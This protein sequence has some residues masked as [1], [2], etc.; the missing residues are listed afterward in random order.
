MATTKDVT[1]LYA[2]RWSAS[3]TWGGEVPPKEGETVQIPA[4]LTLL[5]DVPTPK[6]ML[7]LIEGALIVE[8]VPGITLDANYIFINRGSFQVG[9]PALPYQ[10]QFTLTLHGRRESPM[11]PIYGNKVLAVYRGVLDMHGIPRTV[12]WTSLEYTINPYASSFTVQVATDW[13]VGESVVVASTSYDHTDAE[14]RVITAVSGGGKEFTVSKPFLKKHYAATETYGSQTIEM[15]AEVGLLTRNVRVRGSEEGLDQEHGAHIMAYSKGDDSVIARITYI[16]IFNAGQA[17]SIGAYPIHFHMIGAVRNS[18]IIGNGIHH[19]FNRAITIHAIQYL[20]VI[21]NVSY[22]TKGHTIFVEDGAEMKNRIVHNLVVSVRRSWSR[23]NT[24]TTPAGIWVTNPDNYVTDNHVAGSDAYGIWFDFKANP[25][26]PSATTL[27]CPVGTPLAEFNNNVAHSNGKYGFRLFH[28]HIP[29]TYPC[30]PAT[31][32]TALDPWADNPPVTA[33]YRNFVGYKN[34]R[35]GAIAD[36]VGDVRWQNFKVADNLLA[37]IEITY[38]LDT[39]PFTIPFLSNAL[40]IGKSLNTEADVSM[41]GSIG[42]IGPQSDGLI[43]ENLAFYN[44]DNSMYALGDESHSSACTTR[45]HGGRHNKLRGLTFGNANKRVHWEFPRRSFYEIEDAS[46][47]GRAGAFVA[48]FWPHLLWEPYCTYDEATYNGIICDGT[49]VIRRVHMLDLQPS[50]TFGLMQIT[51]RRAAGSNLPMGTG[52]FLPSEPNYWWTS[53]GPVGG[54]QYHN[55]PKAWAVPMIMGTEYLVH[56]GTTPM[57][58]TSMTIRIE[59][60]DDPSLWVHVRF[61]FTD[62]REMFEVRRGTLPAGTKS[63][64]VG[65]VD[66]TLLPSQAALTPTSPA[67]ASSFDNTTAMEFRTVLTGQPVIKANSGDLQVKAYRCYGGHCTLKLVDDNVTM[68]TFKR[69]WSNPNSWPSGAIPVEGESVTIE[70]GWSM[71]LD[72]NTAIMSF[73]EVNGDLVFDNTTS[74]TLN[75][76]MIHVRKGRILS[77]SQQYPLLPNITHQIVINGTFNSL[78]YAFDPNIEVVNKAL[79]ITGNM[80]LYGA[81]RRAWV[82]LVQN[83]KPGDTA[84]FVERTNWQAGDQ[85]VLTSSSF[86]QNETETNTVAS[87]QGGI[88][89]VTGVNSGVDL[90]SDALWTS[91]ESTKSFGRYSKEMYKEQYD[92]VDSKTVTKLTLSQPLQYYHAGTTLLV[93]GSPMDMRGEVGVLTSNIIIRGTENG[94]T[95]NFVVADFVDY[96]VVGSNPILR[97]GSVTLDSI[98]IDYCGQNSTLRTGLR[99][100]STTLPSVVSN[101]IV[102]RSQTYSVNIQNSKNVRLLGNTFFYAVRFGVFVQ[103]SSDLLIDGNLMINVTQRPTISLPFDKPTGYVICPEER[104]NC[105]NV[106]VSNNVAAGYALLGFADGGYQCGK[107]ATFYN[108]VAHSGVNGWITSNTGAACVEMSGFRSYFNSETAVVGSMDG[109]EIIFS[110]LQIADS[111]NG[112]GGNMGGERDSGNL[113][114]IKDSLIVGKTGHSF[115]D[116]NECWTPQCGNRRGIIFSTYLVEAKQWTI[117]GKLKLPIYNVSK[118]AVFNAE[119]HY[120]N[121]VFANFNS[122]D[123]CKA[124]ITALA[125]NELSSDYTPVQIFS[126]VKLINVANDSIFYMADPDPQWAS[127]LFCGEFPCTGL[128]NA[129]VRDMDGGLVGSSNGGYLLPNNPGIIHREGCTFVGRSNGYMCQ[130]SQLYNYDY[131]LL[132]FE[133]LDIDTREVTISPIYIT[134]EDPILNVNSTHYYNK[135]NSFMSHIWDGFYVGTNRLGR[136]PTAIGLNRKFNVTFTATAPERMR[137]QLQGALKWT[138]SVVLTVNYKEPY[139]VKVKLNGTEQWY[140]PYGQQVN[141]TAPSGT[142]RWLHEDRMMQFIIRPGDIVEL[143]K[144]DCIQ[145]SIR[146]NM[147]T[148]EFFATN[149]QTE[150]VDRLASVLGIPPYRIRVASIRSGSTICDTFINADE[151]LTSKRASSTSYSNAGLEDLTRLNALLLAKASNGTL[152]LNAP[153]LSVNSSI[154][155]VSPGLSPGMNSNSS[156]PTTVTPDTSPVDITDPPGDSDSSGSITWWGILLITAGSLAAMV[157][158]VGVSLGVYCWM[159]KKAHV[160]ATELVTQPA[161]P[162]S[163]AAKADTSDKLVDITHEIVDFEEDENQRPLSEIRPKPSSPQKSAHVSVHW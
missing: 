74:V 137:Y 14:E 43:A 95:C 122:T 57:D 44:F 100:E 154:V 103:H 89:L 128:R 155:A 110:N 5:L 18:F 99:F 60:F 126:G 22:H 52:R 47:N 102:K 64:A 27:I 36:R 2:D 11:M 98:A 19:T 141:L 118:E 112:Y 106:V 157:F 135:L 3:S 101:S 114:T 13:K 92:K 34:K 161:E 108:N 159:R 96:S 61:N 111:Y 127:L 125:T 88:D 158:L 131:A 104:A 7:L 20:R 16:E 123:L 113:V 75:A 10:N 50:Q 162:Q 86:Y 68:E 45:D 31:N 46:Y 152:I 24:D 59:T 28:G 82:R 151:A 58:W 119:F 83:A 51:V 121:I 117:N 54:A 109:K 153:V 4:G 97:S 149:G 139:S 15:R 33:V 84:I 93:N 115:C 26:G 91:K 72:T 145:V 136:F 41:D 62:H 56:W 143:I 73:L 55:I 21:D 65:F 23:L 79:I 77:G 116:P 120:E 39:K 144:V 70:P 148:D 40:I 124:N 133:N 71:I 80:Q 8:D 132:M 129:I 25:T 85:I 134:S 9:T 107:T 81:K 147:T 156:S 17:Y 146:M 94:W 63:S 105:P 138:D 48:A 49:K 42:F 163:P 130:K 87:V 78:A 90:G 32:S 69:V 160:Q 150:F 30:L 12:T 67:G 140:L 38:T 142:N 1:F 53:M 66:P 35:N 37:G 29:R 76:N 6:L